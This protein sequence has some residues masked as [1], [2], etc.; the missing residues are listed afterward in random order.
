MKSEIPD[1]N[2]S[3]DRRIVEMN[4][5]LLLG[6][7]RQHELTEA[8]NTANALLVAEISERKQAEKALKL[9]QLELA[10]RAGQLEGLVAQRTAELVAINAQLEAFVYTIAHDLRAPLRSMQGFSA[11]LLDEADAGLSA[12]GRE[13]AHRISKS[14]QFMDA[15]LRGLLDFSRIAQ[16]EITL[17]NVDLDAVVRGA[18]SRLEAESPAESFHI[19]MTGG[20]PRV[21]AHETTLSQIITNLLTNAV[22]FCRSGTPQTIHLHAEDLG[23]RVRL[24]VDD[25]GIGIAP[26]HRDQIFRLFTRLHGERFPGTGI[27][28]AI[29]QKGIERMNGSA[30]VEPNPGGGSRFWIELRKAKEIPPD[31]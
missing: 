9:A 24:W 29:V 5:A 26:D 31:E 28:L 3:H 13:F 22:K 6:S 14:A 10:D 7:L 25:R 21:I 11:A 17:K 20:W 18:I 19:E 15:L 27:G 1:R 8:A 2:V 12:N 16:Q 23:T 30:G 4:E